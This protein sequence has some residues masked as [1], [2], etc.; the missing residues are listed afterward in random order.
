MSLRSVVPAGVLVEESRQD[1]TTTVFPAEEAGIAGAVPSRRAEFA[2]TRL[3]ARR[4]LARLGFVAS[5]IPVG[6]SRQPLLPPGIVGSLT[7]CDGYRGSA[8]CRAQVVPALGVD[9]EPCRQLP[10]DLRPVVA[11]SDEL[12][13]PAS[14]GPDDLD[15]ALL[16]FSIKESVYKAWNPITGRWLGFHDVRVRTRWRGRRS[17]DFRADV[18]IARSAEP[19]GFDGR[20]AVQDALLF[21]AAWS[22]GG[23]ATLC[24]TLSHSMSQTGYRAAAR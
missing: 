12:T 13:G 16:L 9:V 4:A 6:P 8:L 3:C 22:T 2:T 10:A 18:L 23:M 17:G 7:H 20:F 5:A 14:T 21:T 1:L 19:A 11:R 15:P 24:S